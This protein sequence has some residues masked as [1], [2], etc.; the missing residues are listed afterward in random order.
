VEINAVG[1]C[2][3]DFG[4]RVEEF[5][6]GQLKWTGSLAGEEAEVTTLDECSTTLLQEC[7][8]RLY[9]AESDRLLKHEQG[10]FDISNAIAEK[11]TEAIRTMIGGFKTDFE[12]CGDQ[13]A[14]AKAKAA[15][16][17]YSKKLKK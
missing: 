9:Q 1:D 7:I 8:D 4:P 12:A 16:K 5:L 11:S 17:G 13:K 3:A 14:L 2:A 6:K 15:L 10:H